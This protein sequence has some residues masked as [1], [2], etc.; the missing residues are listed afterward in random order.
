MGHM[1]G[2]ENTLPM[3]MGS[4]PF[5]NLEMGGMFTMVKVRDQLRRGDYSDPG[6]Y[7]NP[8]GTLARRVGDDANFG[9]PVRRGAPA[10]SIPPNEPAPI[11]HSEM[12]HST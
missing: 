12:N 5:G 6:W 3:M 11:D 4:G 1:R 9:T 8:R 10:E 2:P 7:P